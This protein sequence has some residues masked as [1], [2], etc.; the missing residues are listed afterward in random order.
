MY[1]SMKLR[2][3]KRSVKVQE[4]HLMQESAWVNRSSCLSAMTNLVMCQVPNFPRAEV[5]EVQLQT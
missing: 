2:L 1:P 3:L 4:I 5:V